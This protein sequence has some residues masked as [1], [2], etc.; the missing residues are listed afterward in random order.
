[1]HSNVLEIIYGRTVLSYAVERIEKAIPQVPLI[2]TTDK[3]A[4]NDDINRYCHRA[5]LESYCSSR[6]NIYSDSL[7]CAYELN[8]DYVIL[9][10]GD[11]LFADTGALQAMVAIACTDEF[12]LITN[13]TGETFPKGMEIEILKTSFYHA[14]LE[15]VGK[16]NQYNNFESY[17][18]GEPEAGKGK[19]YV[20]E[21]NACPNATELQLTLDTPHGVELAKRIIR[22]SGFSPASLSLQE[23]YN[24]SIT[25]NKSYP[26]QG[27]SGPLL[28]A[29]VGGNHEGD[30][31]VAKAMAESAISGGA[32]CVKFQLYSGDTLVSPVESP[33]RHRHF[34]KFELSREQHIHLAEMCRAAGVSYLAS[35]WDL[36]MLDWIDPYLD[37]YKIGSGDMTAWPIIEAFASKGKPILLSVGLSTME[38]VLQTVNFIQKVNSCYFDPEMLCILQCTSMYPIPDEDANLCVID[39]LRAVTHL[40]IGYSDHTIGMEALRTAAAM[41]ADVLEFHFTDSRE[42]KTFRDHQVSLVS[43]EVAQLKKDI[44]K[45][46]T[47]RGKGFKVPQSSELDSEHDISFRR[48]VYLSREVKEGDIIHVDDLVFLR[49]AHGTDARDIDLLVGARALR[50]L[51]PYEALRYGIDCVDKDSN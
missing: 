36:D 25:S 20:Y 40:A 21:N 31:E 50:D 19:S 18:Y 5:G 14:A 8:W 24:K 23:I 22:N 29:E 43:D 51:I 33:D 13:L 49:P 11:S 27:S 7:A 35:V 28:I 44:L 34:Q 47:L 2:V 17:I 3:S 38:E 12:D 37:F 39:T 48:G 10:H 9:V 26:W 32:D 4:A 15:N 41:G 6:N 16:K 46:T 45:I 1:M 42:G 30:F